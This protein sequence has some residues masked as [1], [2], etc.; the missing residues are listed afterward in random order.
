MGI[1]TPLRGRVLLIGVWALIGC[2]AYDARK[3]EGMNGAG[4]G[5]KGATM[6]GGSVRDGSL[7][8][9]DQ[10]GDDAALCVEPRAEECN[11]RDDD[12]DG[13]GDDRDEDTRRACTAMIPNAALSECVALRGEPRCVLRTCLDGF[14]NCDGIPSNG[15]E[16]YCMCHDCPDNDGGA[17]PDADGGH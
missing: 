17:E 7:G 11:L 15:C 10:P 14:W 12:C 6:D 1:A 4:A 2:H 9:A 5:G 13:L 3:L 16:P 8:D